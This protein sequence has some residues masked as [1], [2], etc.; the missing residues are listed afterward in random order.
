MR[1]ARASI[2]YL[3]L[4]GG[5]RRPQAAGG[6]SDSFACLPRTYAPPPNPPP[7]RGRERIECAVNAEAVE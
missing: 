7:F 5:G 6:G 3:S 1:A 4:K 2:P